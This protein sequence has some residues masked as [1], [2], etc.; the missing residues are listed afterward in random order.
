MNK[1]THGTI[2]WHHR[3]AHLNI[4]SMKDFFLKIVIMPILNFTQLPFCE[5]Y[6]MGKHHKDFFSPISNETPSHAIFNLVHSNIC[7]PCKKN[8]GGANYFISFIND[9][10]TY[11]YC[12]L[13]IKKNQRL[14]LCFKHIRPW[15]KNKMIKSSKCYATTMGGIFFLCI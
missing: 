6:N 5:G 4:F 1:N 10:S 7:G 2:Q 3:L 15:W 12:L 14:L 8:L 13:F 9:Y 11:T